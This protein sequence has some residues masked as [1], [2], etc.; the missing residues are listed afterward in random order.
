MTTLGFTMGFGAQDM[1]MENALGSAYKGMN[2][3]T[4]FVMSSGSKVVKSGYMKFFGVIGSSKV[5]AS[6]GATSKILDNVSSSIKA[7]GNSV[8]ESMKFLG[9][10]FNS[11]IGVF[12]SIKDGVTDA[13]DYL[14]DKAREAYQPFKDVAKKISSVMKK[15]FTKVKK[16]FGFVS[17]AGR[18]FSKT[19]SPV[20]KKVTKGFNIL[21]KGVNKTIVSLKKL[22]KLTNGGMSPAPIKKVADEVEKVADN[23][24]RAEFSIKKLGAMI[25]KAGKNASSSGLNTF[26]SGITA[27]KTTQIADN[28]KGA[29]ATTGE[30]TNSMEAQF[31]SMN[32]EVRPIIT[33]LGIFG[34]EASKV[35]SMITSTAFSLNVGAGQVASA[36]AGLKTSGKETT[37]MFKKMGLG[38]KDLVKLEI[39]T[40]YATKDLAHL[41]SDMRKSWG[42][43]DK[44]IMN[45]M[46]TITKLSLVTGRGGNA[47][48]D[49]KGTMDALTD[50]YSK[51]GKSMDP[52]DI[53][54]IAIQ[55]EKLAG[56]FVKVLG[57]A[58]EEA[59]K[60]ALAVVQKMV[61]EQLNMKQMM[62]G[63]GNE[64][65][66]TF[67]KFATVTKYSN[68]A[69]LF[70]EKDPAKFAIAISKIGAEIK[71]NG[72]D[73]E[74]AQFAKI[75]GDMSPDFKFLID[76]NKEVVKSFEKMDKATKNV[77]GTM[78]KV[79]KAGFTTGR[80]L[81]EN[82]QIMKD[83][84]D[85]QLRSISKGMVGDFMNSQRQGFKTLIG[86]VKKYSDDETWGPL[87]KRFSLVS[88]V[89]LHGLFIPMNKSMSR[90]NH[91]MNKGKISS[92][93]YAKG[94]AANAK[95]ASKVK[96]A[97]G[98]GGI[99]GRIKALKAGGIATM[100]V[101]PTTSAK[102]MALQLDEAKGKMGGIGAAMTMLGQAFSQ[103]SKM[104]LPLLTAL[105]ALTGI[106]SGLISGIG[107]LVKVVM[108]PLVAILGWPIAIGVALVAG[109]ALFTKFGGKYA[110][111]MKSFF[112]KDNLKKAGSAI[113]SAVSKFGDMFLSLADVLSKVDW[114]GFGKSLYK[115]FLI[116]F[117]FV[118]V[119][120]IPAIITLA[121]KISVAFSM[122]AIGLIKALA[123]VLFQ[124]A[125][126]AIPLIWK[127][128]K[129]VGTI[130]FKAIS[131]LGKYVGKIIFKV[132]WFVIK[133]ASMM[134]AY[135]FKMIIKGV[136]KGITG[137]IGAIFKGFSWLV[138][139]AIPF[140]GNKIF[141]L[142][143]SFIRGFANIFKWIGDFTGDIGKY[144][145]G[146]ISRGLNWLANQVGSLG[147]Y[148]WGI[149]SGI[150]GPALNIIGNLGAMIVNKLAGI[151]NLIWDGMANFGKDLY[152][153]G[154]QL[155]GFLW[156]G[157]NS[158][159]GSIGGWISSKWSSFSKKLRSM[160]SKV[161]SAL[162]WIG[163]KIGGGG[164]KKQILAAI[165]KAKAIKEKDKINAMDYVSNEKAQIQMST[166]SSNIKMLRRGD[167]KEVANYGSSVL[168]K[169]VFK[170]VATSG[171]DYSEKDFMK[172]YSKKYQLAIR[173]GM[174]DL[175]RTSRTIGFKNKEAAKFAMD[176]MLIRAKE[177]SF[178]Y[179]YT[180][181]KSK[182]QDF[183]GS[184]SS[185]RSGGMGSIKVKRPKFMS[186]GMKPSGKL[187]KFK[188]KTAPILSKLGV[189]SGPKSKISKLD[190]GDSTRQLA[191]SDKTGDSTDRW[192]KGNDSSLTTTPS[193]RSAY[194]QVGGGNQALI[195]TIK[196]EGRATRSI[197]NQISTNTGR[198]SS[199]GMPVYIKAV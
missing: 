67:S 15:N 48:Q 166:T 59:G 30:L 163:N 65:S 78:K 106:F 191:G 53:M 86:W 127:A 32:K 66:T 158:I 194:P 120:V 2:K 96:D 115:G 153:A 151:P 104:M 70:N 119:R 83:S 25:A 102:D 43:N 108:F 111:K 136:W 101:K 63:L 125:K 5:Q 162:T 133:Y 42:M 10:K 37:A 49:L 135:I 192:N 90:L 185:S 11:F 12:G 1:G 164:M 149:F 22:A 155:I 31:T 175:S 94:M 81:Q 52:K 39:T 186:K 173:R 182:Q 152:G 79:S 26:F 58:P 95:E 165:K 6:L 128:I 179:L 195:E 147:K 141:E 178:G 29:F 144:I 169:N 134:V 118:L 75:V 38:L 138:T 190:K 197:L 36:Y 187:L 33:R 28:V 35:R 92:D 40:G 188:H 56:V 87:T 17:K 88:Q 20:T 159:L 57:T 189:K 16:G 14:K 46:E 44:Q 4:D 64:Y 143:V 9:G 3:F 51:M 124:F 154:R 82:M 19:M 145:F 72:S 171:K 62:A 160:A 139:T 41:A 98:K 121:S 21:R 161:G 193:G 80:T 148:V 110:D 168:S 34:K 50:T 146:G 180:G 76:R 68:V 131:W 176:Q 99:L 7:V 113:G 55:S 150:F 13:F 27:M 122:L 142:G 157:I 172:M 181:P 23:S 24:Q 97:L 167:R 73:M 89:G 69:D 93:Q 84:F 112:S 170:D 156:N 114:M 123:S 196:A 103:V 109:L 130:L 174:N 199:R 184:D 117:G 107:G 54:K 183:M 45:T 18:K 105:P 85:T 132:A 198:G 126:D 47:F 8:A 61:A 129:F 60:K 77:E 100:W 71:K 177:S 91:L 137:L 74:N 140:I 116:A